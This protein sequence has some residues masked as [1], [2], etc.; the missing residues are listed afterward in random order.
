MAYGLKLFGWKPAQTIFDSTFC[1]DPD[2]ENYFA[3]QLKYAKK[4]FENHYEILNRRL[5]CIFVT[6]TNA[7]S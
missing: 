3:V 2:D 7:K 5:R 1:I 6:G 4:N